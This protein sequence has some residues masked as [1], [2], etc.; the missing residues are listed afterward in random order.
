MIWMV[1]LEF[2]S[3]NLVIDVLT[4]TCELFVFIISSSF[5]QQWKEQKDTHRLDD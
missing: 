3:F 4:M 5:D 2:E 1:M